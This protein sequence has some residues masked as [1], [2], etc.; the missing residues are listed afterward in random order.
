MHIESLIKISTTHFSQHVIAEHTDLSTIR[1]IGF[2]ATCSLVVIGSAGQPLTVSASNDGLADHNIMLWMD[3]RATAETTAINGTAHR[4]LRFVGGRTSPEAQ[5]PKMLWLK[6]HVP[7]TWRDAQHFFDLPD[8]LTWRSTAAPV[9]SLCSVVAK[10]NYDAVEGGWCDEW[11]EAIGL[12]E[13]REN[14]FERIG[15]CAVQSPGT[16][17]G[18]GLSAE[19][20]AELGLLAGTPVGASLVDAYAGGL[21]LFGC[22]AEEREDGA[23]DLEDDSQEAAFKSRMALI[24]GTSTGHMSIHAE[25]IWARGAWG[26]FRGVLFP[27]QFVHSAG[28]SC[29][30]ILVDHIIRTHPAYADLLKAAG[31]EHSHAYLNRVLVELAETRGL[32]KAEYHRLTADLHVWPDFHG[33]RSPLDDPSLRGMLSGLRMSQDVNDLAVLYLAFVQALA[34]S[35]A[36]VLQ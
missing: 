8:F 24:C 3:H 17:I 16:P 5:C 23:S 32:Q 26:P 4:L 6:R 20:A 21:S 9:R 27:G 29:S 1:G 11:F 22:R 25:P 28:Q 18:G 30:G 33:N 34:V 15:G 19:A 2:D 13:L 10:F 14:G 36:A 12:G 35:W 31:G 7:A